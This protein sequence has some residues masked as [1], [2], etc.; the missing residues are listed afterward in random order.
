MKKMPPLSQIAPNG[1][2]R[3]GPQIDGRGRTGAVEFCGR[4]DEHANF[5]GH[6]T[7]VIAIA[8]PLA[9]RL[10]F[11]I[12]AFQNTNFRCRPVEHG[13]RAGAFFRYSVYIGE[14]GTQQ[15]VSLG[16]DLMGGSI[17][18]VQRPG[19]STNIDAERFPGKRLLEYT[20]T[21][22]AGEEEAVRSSG[23]KRGEKP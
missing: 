3:R 11:F 18:D 22:I 2:S 1:R 8:E 19:A 5:V 13:N 16:A 23:S 15:A 12:R 6:D 9:A 21:E 10:A 14:F 4:A 17:I 20:L 7:L